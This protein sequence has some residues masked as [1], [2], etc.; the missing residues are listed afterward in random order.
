ML[1]TQNC[2][3]R[4]IDLCFWIVRWS[5]VF[6]IYILQLSLAV[7][8]SNLEYYEFIQNIMNSYGVIASCSERDSSLNIFG[9]W[10]LYECHCTTFSWR[11]PMDWGLGF[12][13]VSLHHFFLE[14]T[15]IQTQVLN[16]VNLCILY[17][18]I[19]FAFLFLFCINP[20]LLDTLANNRHQSI[21]YFNILL[22]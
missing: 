13:R 4:P 20:L 1:R 2:G 21:C 9:I 6:L 15:Y 10:V 22:K 11:L 14:T 12:I 19:S 3:R 17:L 8:E 18:I 7:C 16:H 5:Q